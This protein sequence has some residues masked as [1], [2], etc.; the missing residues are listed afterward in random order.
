[1]LIWEGSLADARTAL[2]R[3]EADLRDVDRCLARE[4]LGIV[5]AWRQVEAATKTAWSRAEAST[6]ESKKEA[7]DAEAAHDDAL[8]EAAA[9]VKRCSEAEA[10]LKALQEEQ[11]TR[12]KRLQQLEDDLK[13]REAELAGHDSALAKVTAEQAAERERLTKPQK[14]VTEAQASHTRHAY[15]VTARL[16][17]REQE[18]LARAKEKVAATAAPSPPLSQGSPSA[19]VHLQ[20][21]I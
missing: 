4:R 16:D 21:R 17:T 2:G 1:M 15:E 12:A 3:F 20:G 11:S 8:V 18:I 10:G 5:S 13:A 19:A 9:A 7:A 14:E 6:T